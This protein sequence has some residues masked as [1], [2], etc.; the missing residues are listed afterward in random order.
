VSACV[1]LVDVATQARRAARQD[2]VDDRTLLPTPRRT[3]TMKLVGPQV[4]IEDLRDLVPRSLG[5][6]LED[7]QLRAQRIQWTSR[8]AHTLRG[9]VRIDLRRP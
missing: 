6:L 3:A 8:R 7:H 9:H 2:C 4:P 5:H 1:A